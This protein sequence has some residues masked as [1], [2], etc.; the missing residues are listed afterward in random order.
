MER[1]IP[2]T[3]MVV[4]VLMAVFQKQLIK[5]IQDFPSVDNKR[6][7][8]FLKGQVLILLFVALLFG[9]NDIKWITTWKYICFLGLLWTIAYVDFKKHIIPNEILLS[10]IIIKI[11]LWGVELGIVRWNAV[12]GLLFDL[13]GCMIILLFSLTIRFLS[14]KGLGMGDVKLFS[15]M[16]LFFGSLAALE[17]LMWSMIVSFFMACYLLLSK[18]R[19]KTD[20]M[21]FAPSALVGT[22]IYMIISVI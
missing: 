21:P 8:I 18:K 9:V 22:I 3:G 17:V 6:D 10:A 19:G 20:V 13:V 15:M 7:E 2:Y 16:P 12:T 14:K 4:A 11:V 1:I 5:K